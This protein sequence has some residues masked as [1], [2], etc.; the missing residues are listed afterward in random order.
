LVTEDELMGLYI[1]ILASDAETALHEQAVYELGRAVA[2][3]RLHLELSAL[4]ERAPAL[5]DWQIIK[6]VG[7]MKHGEAQQAL[8]VACL[9]ASELGAK[10]R[11]AAG[12]ALTRQANEQSFDA[13]TEQREALNGLEEARWGNQFLA[14]LEAR[15]AYEP[16][17]KRVPKSWR[18][19]EAAPELAIAADTFD[20]PLALEHRAIAWPWGTYRDNAEARRAFGDSLVALSREL[21]RYGQPWSTY[22][23]TVFW[24]DLRVRYIRQYRQE[25]QM[26][27]ERGFNMPPW[28]LALTEE[29]CAEIEENVRRFI[30]RWQA[31]GGEGLGGGDGG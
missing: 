22:G 17:V 11:L 15:R 8:L 24:L 26:A 3:G 18:E 30:E 16:K 20:H 19:R 21:E 9:A 27:L 12:S 1:E 13:L 29:E 14:T 7:R 28:E 31:G 6:G 23:D 25:R 10:A 4:K 2:S 5:D